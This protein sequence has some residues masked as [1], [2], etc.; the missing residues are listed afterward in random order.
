MSHIAA[1]SAA[2]D[3][4][5]AATGRGYAPTPWRTILTA[6]ALIACASTLLT[7]AGNV[8]WGTQR[9]RWPVEIGRELIAWSFWAALT[10]LIFRLAR[11]FP[12]IGPGW[13]RSIGIHAIA[14]LGLTVAFNAIRIAESAAMG[15]ITMANLFPSLQGVVAR[16]VFQLFVYLA[17]VAIGSAADHAR[18]VHEHDRRAARLESHLLAAKLSALRAQLQP[19]FLFNTLHTVA[20]LIRE[21]AN[22]EALGVVL[23]L[24]DLL[25]RVVDDTDTE[26]IP[27]RRELAFLE[28]YVEIERV[29]FDESLTVTIEADPAVLDAAVPPLLLQP[30]VENALRHG[31]ADRV[32]EGTVQV[33]A[34]RGGDTVTI[35]VVDNGPGYETSRNP[36]QRGV[37]LRNI[38]QRLDGLY[39]GQHGLDITALAGRG[40]RVRLTLPYRQ[41]AAV[42]DD[43]PALVAP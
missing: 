12:I 18:L 40:T 43:L 42:A 14:G 4:Q 29:R 13:W 33:L 5:E 35:D 39:P 9:F 27:L 41:A 1:N 6:W 24:S 25:R 17:V 23:N 26:Q 32:G 34:T 31:V 10:P 3:L 30:I 7:F 8:M 16:V 21:H 37:G 38:Q 11:R 2:P 28:R 22:E 20:L 19:H 36:R 15:W